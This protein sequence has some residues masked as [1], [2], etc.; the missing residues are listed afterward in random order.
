MSCDRRGRSVLAGL[1]RASVVA[2]CVLLAGTDPAGAR[3]WRQ[4]APDP[5]ASDSSY[6]ALT[7]RTPDSLSSS[8]RAWVG[9]QRQWR[10]Q[11]ADEAAG[12]MGSSL[13]SGARA[14]HHAHASDERFAVLASRPFAALTDV[15]LS[16]LVSESAVQRQEAHQSA[17][18]GF[19]LL[20]AFLLT[21][22][23]IVG[24][25]IWELEHGDLP[26]FGR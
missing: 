14:E 24:V 12:T 8:E 9:V 3:A 13:T 15:E 18:N 26:G 6:L 10:E 4:W 25:A 19:A 7:A 11:R 22:G 20:G 5:L 21:L 17:R 1:G 2:A 23:V 16:W